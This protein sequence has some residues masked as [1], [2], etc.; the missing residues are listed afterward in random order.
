MPVEEHPDSSQGGP[1]GDV[2]HELFGTVAALGET[3]ELSLQAFSPDSH[4]GD[5]VRRFVD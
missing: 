2:W 4:V 5:K 3:V 1:Q